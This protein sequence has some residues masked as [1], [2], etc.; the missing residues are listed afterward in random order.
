MTE[1]YDEF[2]ISVLKTLVIC[3][4]RIGKIH[5]HHPMNS[6][7]SRGNSIGV[8]NVNI[9]EGIR[10]Y[11]FAVLCHGFQPWKGRRNHFPDARDENQHLQS[12]IS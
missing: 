5:H 6:K 10:F 3:V 12:Q 8:A 1:S 7:R 11:V 4:M 9:L 2:I